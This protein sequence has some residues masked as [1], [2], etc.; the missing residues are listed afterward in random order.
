[1]LNHKSVL[2]TGG[3]GSFGK[4]FIQ[5]ILARYPNVKKIIVY[6]RDELKQFELKQQYP[7]KEYPQMRFFIGD[8][9][10]SERLVQAC[11]G[12][13]VIIHA[14]A[15][16][17]VDTA[18][19]NP[20]ECIRTNISGA[21]NV[22]NAALKCGVSNV[23]ALSTDKACAPINLY[24]ATKLASDKL[25]TAANNIKGSRDLKFSVVRYGNVMGSRGSVIPFFL[26]KRHE[27][28]LPITHK[29]MTRFNISLQDGVDMV[30]YALKN[31]LGGEIFVPKIPSY[32]ILD[33]AKAVAPDCEIKV[34][35]V[36]PGEKLHEE[37]ITDTDSLN[38]I[39]LGHYYAILPSVSYTYSEKE[40]MAH[41]NAEKVPFGFK[42]NSGTNEQWE[43]VDSLREKI[44]QYIDPDFTVATQK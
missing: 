27:G 17:Q 14:A 31:H 12:V 37:M 1:M 44:K 15:I 32:K 39:D 42:Y 2:I 8:V 43:S 4:Q 35:G 7:H 19:Y 9:R 33:V 6:S 13:D 16:K 22:I 24:G 10:D 36:R 5:T 29:D 38:T 34:I 25:F 23:V 30:M 11:E 41:H 26:N 40:Y 3:T 28:V 20:T 21:E 18:E